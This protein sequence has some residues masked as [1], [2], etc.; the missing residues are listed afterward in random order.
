MRKLIPALAIVAALAAAVP[1]AA[2]VKPATYKGK[3][4]EGTAIT[5][6]VNKKGYAFVQT[7]LPT[8]CVSA[9]GGPPV[10][11]LSV[12]WP[13]YGFLVGREVKVED[14]KSTP[15]TH[16]TVDVRQRR[17]GRVLTG[18]LAMSYSQLSYYNGFRILMCAGNG[19]FKL[20]AR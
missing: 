11:R 8:T 20:R 6:T 18:E 17:K 2:A 16:Y 14:S 13:S 4:K 1:A 9:Q 12:F 3:T 10:S 5:V 7:T 19:S 15:T